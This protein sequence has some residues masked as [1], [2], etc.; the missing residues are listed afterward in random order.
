MTDAEILQAVKTRLG[1][2][3]TYQDELLQGYI[4][5]V[6]NY[7]ADAGVPG[8]IL[9][10][11]AAAGAVARVFSDLWNT[12]GGEFSPYFYQRVSQLRGG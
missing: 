11:T 7:M 12:P 1:I 5:D 6:M 2:T 9:R 4:A 8:D 3:G 10:S